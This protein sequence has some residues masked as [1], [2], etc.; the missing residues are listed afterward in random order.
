MKPRQGKGAGLAGGGVDCELRAQGFGVIC[1]LDEVGRGALAGPVIVAAV[2]SA[3][4]GSTTP[5]SSPPAAV[6]PLQP[7]WRRKR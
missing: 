1:G 4:P 7:P 2:L 5:R 6:R 3:F